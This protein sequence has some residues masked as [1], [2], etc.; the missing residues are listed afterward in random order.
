MLGS[1]YE[2]VAIRLSPFAIRR[3]G[4]KGD[5]GGWWLVAGGWE[6]QTTAGSSA[7]LRFARNDT[8]YGFTES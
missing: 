4:T 2:Q 6:L 3:T 7:P 8:R 1:G 5:L